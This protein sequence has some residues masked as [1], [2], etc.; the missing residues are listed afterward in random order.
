M[1]NN[2]DVTFPQ[3]QREISLEGSVSPVVLPKDFVANLKKGE[4]TPTVRNLVRLRAGGTAVTITDFLHG[5]DGQCIEVLGDGVTD[6]QNNA[7]IVRSTSGVLEE[8]RIYRYTKYSD[9]DDRTILRWYEH[10]ATGTGGAGPAGPAGI[11]GEQGEDGEQGPQGEQGIPGGG[12]L[13]HIWY[14]PEVNP[15]GQDEPDYE[16]DFKTLTAW[17][18]GW[19]NDAGGD[20]ADQDFN[21]T[22][23][24]ALW[25]KSNAGEGFFRGKNHA[26][27]ILVDED[28]CLIWRPWVV[29]TSG[30]FSLMTVSFNAAGNG[31]FGWHGRHGGYG[32]G[33]TYGYEI[34]GASSYVAT[35]YSMDAG[36]TQHP[37]F[38]GVRRIGSDWWYGYSIDGSI[39]QEVPQSPGYLAN[40][41][42]DLGILFYGSNAIPSEGAL[43]VFR[44]WIGDGTRKRSGKL[45]TVES[46]VQGEPGLPGGFVPTYVLPGETFTVPENRQAL[47]ALPIVND[48]VFIID[49]NLVA[50]D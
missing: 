42:I 30:N 4:A 13:T 21:T 1:K 41:D 24:G 40:A 20:F 3:E 29:G 36:K 31:I 28:F 22:R 45:V 14:D 10:A 12:G 25:V 37:G 2:G 15:E 35:A 49:G 43:S 17:P 9:K 34:Y 27:L 26:S 16:L 48:G 23:P 5:Q 19:V 32:T 50:V 47:Y 33:V 38:M 6:V 8:G 39:W 7:N 46:G 11:Q 44:L 18:S